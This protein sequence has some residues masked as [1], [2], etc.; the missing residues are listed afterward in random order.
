[1][2]FKKLMKD[3][4]VSALVIGMAF[5]GFPLSVH[6]EEE[7]A[8]QQEQVEQEQEKVEPEEEKQEQEEEKQEQEEVEVPDTTEEEFNQEEPVEEPTEEETTEENS[9]E[10]TEEESEQEE[11]TQDE[12]TEEKDMEK[13]EDSESEEET[14]SEKTEGIL[15]KFIGFDDEILA[16]V[17]VE[18]ISEIK[19]PE[20]PAVEGYT[21]K[22]WEM[23]DTEA[24]DLEEIEVRAIYEENKTELIKVVFIGFE[25][26]ELDVQEV[27][28][29]ADIKEPE[30]PMIEGYVFKSWD[31]D[32]KELAEKEISEDMLEKGITI[33]AVYTEI[34]KDKL[35]Y[36]EISTT[37]GDKEITISGNL[38]EGAEVSASKQTITSDIEK[39]VTDAFGADD[40]EKEVKITVYEVFDIYVVYDGQKYSPE[41]FGKDTQV[42]IKGLDIKKNEESK[43]IGNREIKSTEELKL[44][45]VNEGGATEVSGASVNETEATFSINGEMSEE[46]KE[47]FNEK[48][49]TSSDSEEDKRDREQPEVEPIQIEGDKREEV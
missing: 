40:T 46:I 8:V 22:E 4:I 44:F 25:D 32:L 20:A 21:F 27:E 36:Q 31:T 14:D 37:L 10:P 24:D 13:E 6:A 5:G 29:L 28:S 3:G 16:E 17:R 2:K 30:V 18:D 9:E 34:E 26:K 41:A 48:A 43:K 15:V 23:S 1:M 19:Y 11:D 7:G 42:S 47:M 45:K 49:E 35:S 39:S 12:D 38:P 33:K